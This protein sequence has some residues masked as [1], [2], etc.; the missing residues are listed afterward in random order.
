MPEIN[1]TPR[2]KFVRVAETRT[3]NVIKEIRKLGNLSNDYY[4]YTQED[5]DLIFSSIMEE[6]ELVKQNFPFYAKKNK[7]TLPR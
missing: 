3:N 5:V 4:E 7:F 1:E 6:I 2:D